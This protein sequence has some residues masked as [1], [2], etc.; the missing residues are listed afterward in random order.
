MPGKGIGH[1]AAT[2]GERM[3]NVIDERLK[4]LETKLEGLSR[5]REVA[6]GIGAALIAAIASTAGAW[7][8][9]LGRNL[10]NSPICGTR[11]YAWADGS[12]APADGAA[13]RR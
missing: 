11:E 1:G 13:R 6:I 12:P 4:H 3:P 8:G 5:S 2:G 10:P 9:F 7:F